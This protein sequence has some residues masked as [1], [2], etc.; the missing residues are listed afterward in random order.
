MT[1]TKSTSIVQAYLNFD[2]RCDEALEF[3][4]RAIGADVTLLMRYKDNPE[5]PQ[6]GAC[7]PAPGSENKVMHASFR[8]GVTELM[9]SD[10]HCGGKPDFK[11]I[12]LSLTVATDAEAEKSFAAL[13]D[14]GVVEMPLAKT[15][16]S[17]RF[18]M[19]ADKFGIGWMILVRQ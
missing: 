5:P 11:G 3:Y 6:P 10:G 8:V 7:G 18:G 14:G 16:F 15:F 2:G 1:T 13:A 4:K 17:S 9:A 19:V 12:R